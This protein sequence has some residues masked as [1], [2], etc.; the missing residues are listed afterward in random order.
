MGWEPL[1]DHVESKDLQAKL[2]SRRMAIKPVLLDQ[3]V[4][5]GIGN[6]YASEALWDARISPLKPASDLTA[7]ELKRL[8]VSVPKILSHALEKGGSTLRDFADPDGN[9]G[10][11]QREFLVYGREDEP[12]DRCG[13]PLAR[14][15]QAQRSTYYCERC[16]KL[17]A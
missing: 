6:I 1:E 10:S 4:W 15:V 13:K 12:C 14:I 17:K 5:A 7:S 3:T 8:I 16:Q 2:A 9:R 11:Y